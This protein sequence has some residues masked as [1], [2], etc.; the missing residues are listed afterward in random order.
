M[1]R[2]LN[3]KLMVLFFIALWLFCKA[4]E[5]LGYLRNPT[6]AE[7]IRQAKSDTTALS[8]EE[9][10]V[11]SSTDLILASGIAGLIA[12]LLGLIIS[13]II[14]RKYKWHW[15]NPVLALLFVYLIGWLQTDK[16]NF[17]GQL[18][19]MPGEVFNGIWYYII[20]G[21][22]SGILGLLMFTF[23]SSMKHPDENQRVPVK[24]L[25]A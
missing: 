22:V 3:I 16:L 7:Q 1:V 18:L 14:C 12:L 6:L 4:G 20:N 24:P 2:R 19:R 10:T 17:V 9:L 11:I 13:L 5:I 15:L 21:S 23:I 25:S 8:S